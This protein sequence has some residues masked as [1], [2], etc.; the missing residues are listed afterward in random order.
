MAGLLEVFVGVLVDCRNEGTV[1]PTATATTTKRDVSTIATVKARLRCPCG[2]HADRPVGSGRRGR[3]VT[4]ACSHRA[5][6]RGTAVSPP[7]R[8]LRWLDFSRRFGGPDRFGRRLGEASGYP[9]DEEPQACGDRSVRQ[10]ICAGVAPPLL[11]EVGRWLL[12]GVARV[13]P[14][15]RRDSAS[16]AIQL[17]C[18]GFGAFSSLSEVEVSAVAMPQYG[19]WAPPLESP[20]ASPRERPQDAGTRRF[21]SSVLRVVCRWV[22]SESNCAR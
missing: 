12:D 15:Q 19:S 13:R 20:Q 17:G 10:G 16:V 2:R 21:C 1:T 7:I 6:G 8:D 22:A 9:V 4:L 5:L 3:V 18:G 14:L 11:V